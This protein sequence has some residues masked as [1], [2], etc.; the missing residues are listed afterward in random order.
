MAKDALESLKLIVEDTETDALKRVAFT[1]LGIGSI[2]GELLAMI[3]ALAKVQIEHLE[4][5]RAS[6]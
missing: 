1:Q 4:E 6:D 2:Y 3:R 5:H